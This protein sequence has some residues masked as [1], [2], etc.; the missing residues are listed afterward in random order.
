MHTFTSPGSP[1]AVFS[2]TSPI[3]PSTPMVNV[4]ASATLEA[5]ISDPALEANV[6]VNVAAA[7]EE[8]QQVISSLETHLPFTYIDVS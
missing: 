4:N 5:L 1:P 7:F 8:L 3:P 6:T 2:N